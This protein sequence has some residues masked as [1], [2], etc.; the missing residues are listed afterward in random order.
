LSKRTGAKITIPKQAD[1]SGPGDD[2]EEDTVDITIEG[3]AVAAELALRRIN[4]IVNE[5]TSSVNYRLKDIPAEFYAFLAGPRDANIQKL[6][7][8][9][10]VNINIPPYNTWQHSAPPDPVARGKFPA[11][12]PQ[13][14]LP[15]RVSGDRQAALATRESI[16][17]QVQALRQQLTSARL[18]VERARHQFLV[19]KNSDSVHDLLAKTGCSVIVPPANDSSEH[20]YII[21]PPDKIEEATDHILDLCSSMAVQIID[22]ARVHPGAPQTHSHDLCRYLQQRQALAAIEEQYKAS[23]TLPPGD[24]DANQPWQI[25]SNDGRQG[26]RARTDISNLIS[27]HPPSRFHPMEVHPYFHQH[28]R[29]N[30]VPQLRR[31]HGVHVLFPSDPESSR[32]VLIYEESGSPAEYEFPR[33]EPS[34]QE[35][36]EYQKAIKK[37]AEELLGIVGP[38]SDIVSRPVNAPQK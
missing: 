1:S 36:Q 28:L 20:L 11:F 26:M 2:D 21:G 30:A 29:S 12:V 6:Q 5:R 16:E 17:R 37:A 32:L 27:A 25:F 9:Q 35:I 10:D 7:G 23:V 31:S 14:S 34:K 24:A 13:P 19:G 8:G 38:N 33:G 22:P 3:D 15:I 4:D 18:P